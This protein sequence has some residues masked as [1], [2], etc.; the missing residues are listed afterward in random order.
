MND[1]TKEELE[2]VVPNYGPNTECDKCGV[3]W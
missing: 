3:I 2:E 1:L